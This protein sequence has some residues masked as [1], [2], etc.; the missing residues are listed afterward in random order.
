[1]RNSAQCR[2]GRSLLERNQRLNIYADNRGTAEVDP[3]KVSDRLIPHGSVFSI[4]TTPFR[5]S[6]SLISKAEV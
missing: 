2:S 3:D 1:M 6:L 5:Y 4:S